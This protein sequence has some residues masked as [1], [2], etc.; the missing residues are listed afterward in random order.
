MTDV[1]REGVGYRVAAYLKTEISYRSQYLGRDC[2]AR[3]G[4]DERSG[5][6]VDQLAESPRRRVSRPSPPPPPTPPP[7]PS[8]SPINIRSPFCSLLKQDKRVK[9]NLK[10]SLKHVFLYLFLS[11]ITFLLA[12]ANFYFI[13][14]FLN[15][16][17][18]KQFSLALLVSCLLALPFSLRTPSLPS[19]LTYTQTPSSTYDDRSVCIRLPWILFAAS[20]PPSVCRLHIL[21]GMTDS[22]V[23]STVA[24]P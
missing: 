21:N 2:D 8:S 7:P 22:I 19:T 20:H 1:E 4:S 13:F 5:G 17:T 10:I 11:F 12:P 15:Q 6:L 24:R 23:K 16:R 18:T 9:E 14:P 3:S